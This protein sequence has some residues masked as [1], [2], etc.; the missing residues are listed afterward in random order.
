MLNQ[1]GK[2]TRIENV[3]KHIDKTWSLDLIDKVDL[4]TKNTRSCRYILVVIVSLTN[5]GR[6]KASKNLKKNN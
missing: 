3:V 5:F 2:I 1:L 6:V 4:E